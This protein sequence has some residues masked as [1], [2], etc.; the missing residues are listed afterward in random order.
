MLLL[1]DVD[2][3]ILSIGG[4]ADHHTGIDRSAR[5]D[6]E[7]TALLG[8]VEAVGNCLTGLVGDQRAALAAGDLT[9]VDIIAG[10]E[11]ADDP[12]AAGIGHELAAVAE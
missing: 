2:D 5:S 12:F 1:A 3:D 6:K 11:G 7:L 8:I 10:E 4:G 9:A